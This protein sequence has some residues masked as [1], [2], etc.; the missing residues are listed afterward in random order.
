MPIL[1]ALPVLLRQ[2]LLFAILCFV[3]ST[4]WLAMKLGIAVVPPAFFSGVRW[5]VAGIAL[6]AWRRYQHAPIGV[7]PRL[8]GRL[9]VLSLFM[10]SLNSSIQLY[11]LR[12]ITTGMAAVINS[13]LT[14]I[15]MLAAAVALRQERLTWRQT[16]AIAVG[17]SGLL[18][19]FGLRA[20]GQMDWR[21][22]LGIILMVVSTLSYCVGSVLSRP[23]LRTMAPVHLAGVTNL[24]G[25]VV[26]LVLSLPLEPGAWQAAGFAWGWRA[27]AG[28]AWLVFAGSLGASIIFF[29]LIRDWGAGRTG[30]YAF[31]TPVIAV[32]LGMAVFGEQ[33]DAAQALGMTLMLVG[34]GLGTTGGRR[35]TPATPTP[36]TA[37]RGRSIP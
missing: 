26:L 36:Q 15:F 20:V 7:S 5:T 1:P 19:L 25:G 27:W 35:D 22:I 31:V 18:V 13:G 10:L 37:A 16:I 24:I 4:T 30:S 33:V 34:A 23:L 28:W 17:V 14:P 29:I 21:E 11:G 6:L 8:V 9:V 2:R 32:A 3:W 12:L